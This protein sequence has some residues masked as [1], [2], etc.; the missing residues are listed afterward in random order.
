M[1]PEGG[2]VLTGMRDKPDQHA[3]VG[4]IMQAITWI[5]DC[6]RGHAAAG[7]G[8][9]REEAHG[10]FNDGCRVGELVEQIRILGDPTCS[11][12]WVR[13][14]DVVMFST[15]IRENVREA[16]KEIQDITDRAAGGVVARKQE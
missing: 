2:I 12:S 1:R 15:D 11:S 13:T 3:W 6:E 9:R 7:G 5:S 4:R 10:L 16:V 8:C 14:D